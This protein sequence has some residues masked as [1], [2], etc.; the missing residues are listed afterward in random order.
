MTASKVAIAA[1]PLMLASFAA[2]E[3]ETSAQASSKCQL[4]EFSPTYLPW[5]K[6]KVG[7]PAK[8][9]LHKRQAVVQW[10]GPSEGRR[11]PTLSLVSGAEI[12]DDIDAYETAPVRGVE[13]HV[14]WVGDP[15]VGEL[16]LLWSEGETPCDAYGLHL[17]D[18][19]LKKRRAEYEIKRIARSLK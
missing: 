5:S 19:S 4:P 12:P 1:L 10:R 6:K 17:F 16:S 18:R 3:P 8:N 15:G 13:G 7:A 14:A 9:V 2:C 11:T